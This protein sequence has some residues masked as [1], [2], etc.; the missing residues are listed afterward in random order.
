MG[1]TNNASEWAHLDLNQVPDIKVIPPGP[2]SKNLHDRCTKYFKG[3]S[4]QVLFF[5]MRSIKS[6]AVTGGMVLM[7]PVRGCREIFFLLWKDQLLLQ[8][9]EW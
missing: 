8:S 4:S 9:M 5:L 7:F 3:L 2:K 1:K 6:Q